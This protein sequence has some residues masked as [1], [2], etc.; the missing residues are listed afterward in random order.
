MAASSHGAGGDA[1]ATLLA[2]GKAGVCIPE[3]AFHPN[4][5]K[6][7]ENFTAATQA[8]KRG[9]SAFQGRWNCR[10]TFVSPSEAGRFD[11]Q[12]IGYLEKV[13]RKQKSVDRNDPGIRD[14]CHSATARCWYVTRSLKSQV[15]GTPRRQHGEPAPAKGSNSA[16]PKHSDQSARDSKRSFATLR[17][18]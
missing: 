2:T 16:G 5:H 6:N 13:R 1:R 3:Y 17:Q 7:G 10:M 9:E 11:A 15:T 8:F 12:N 18:V 4:A 14:R